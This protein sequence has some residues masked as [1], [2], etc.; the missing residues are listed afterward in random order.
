MLRLL[1]GMGP[2][3]KGP[4]QKDL[5][6]KNVIR[7]KPSAA[8]PPANVNAKT[9]G[10]EAPEPAAAMHAAEKCMRARMPAHP[11]RQGM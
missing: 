10:E 2:E 6:G 5:T 1:P 7:L 3:T 11:A 9:I 4:A 8:L